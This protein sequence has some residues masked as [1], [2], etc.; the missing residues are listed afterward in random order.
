MSLGVDFA[1]CIMN[2]NISAKKSIISG[3]LLVEH[4]FLIELQIEIMQKEE[5][6]Y[7]V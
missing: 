5:N 2:L 7:L 3:T 4:N 1:N 6:I